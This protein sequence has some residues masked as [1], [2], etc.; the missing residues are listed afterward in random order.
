[1]QG[2]SWNKF[3]FITVINNR[4]FNRSWSIGACTIPNKVFIVITVGDGTKPG[5][6]RHV[7]GWYDGAPR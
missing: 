7:I 2:A 3:L 6:F 1:M 4:I 5:E